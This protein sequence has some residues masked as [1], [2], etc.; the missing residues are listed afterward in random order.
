MLAIR[1]NFFYTRTVRCE[2]WFMDKGKPEHLRD[3]V[4]MLDARQG[5]FER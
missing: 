1:G 4:L 2:I 3:K 5:S